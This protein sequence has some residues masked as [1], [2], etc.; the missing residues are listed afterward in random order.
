MEQEIWKPIN[1]MNGRYHVSNLGRVKSTNRPPLKPLIDKDG[2]L[3]VSITIVNRENRS[4]KIHRLVCEHFVSDVFPS[5]YHICH[6]DGTRDNNRWDNLYVGTHV[7]NVLD[8]YAQKRTK[9]T[10]EQIRDI[11]KNNGETQ[12]SL[13]DRYGVKQG[14]ISRIKSRK[15]AA[16][17]SE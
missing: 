8:R 3:F 16:F 1:G 11:R 10:P 9:L 5:G 7:T 14:T 15:R 12:Q 13:A 17:I 2:Y 6:R 4:V